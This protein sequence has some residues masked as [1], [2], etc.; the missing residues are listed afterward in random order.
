MSIITKS[1]PNT[2]ESV[3]SEYW[4]F[5]NTN[6]TPRRELNFD[7]WLLDHYRLKFETSTNTDLVVT[8]DDRDILVFMLKFAR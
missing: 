7:R 1:I 4:N 5:Q 6:H 8:G 3:L 2:V